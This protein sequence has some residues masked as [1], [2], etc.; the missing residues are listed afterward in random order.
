MKQ[1]LD[2]LH[3]RRGPEFA[4][5]W[6]SKCRGRREFFSIPDVVSTTSIRF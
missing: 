5:G 4:S 3:L 6:L 2:N 1:V